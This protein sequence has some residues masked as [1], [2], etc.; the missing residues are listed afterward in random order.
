MTDSSIIFNRKKVK[1]TLLD[2]VLTTN[3]DNKTV[4]VIIDSRTLFDIFYIEFYHNIIPDLVKDSNNTVAELF[5]FIG[6][7]HNYFRKKFSNKNEGNK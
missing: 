2:E 3:L 1:Y 4:N 7:Y 5:N 6:H